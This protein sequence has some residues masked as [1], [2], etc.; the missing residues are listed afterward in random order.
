MSRQGQRRDGSSRVTAGGGPG[1]A[2]R[3]PRGGRWTGLTPPARSPE[4]F[5]CAPGSQPQAERIRPWAT[6]R[7]L[8]P[9]LGAPFPDLLGSGSRGPSCGLGLPPRTLPPLLPFHC[10][11]GTQT[12]GGAAR[13]SPSPPQATPGAPATCPHTELCQGAWWGPGALRGPD[14]ASGSLR[15]ALQRQLFCPTGPCVPRGPP[16]RDW[17]R[18]GTGQCKSCT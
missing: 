9:R 2:G 16:V 1:W 3:C 10:F 6:D 13:S 18:A 14:G 5:A 4:V 7:S 15:P 12:H 17:R 11:V 8:L